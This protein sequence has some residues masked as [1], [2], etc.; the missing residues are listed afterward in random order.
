MVSELSLPR[1][2]LWQVSAPPDKEALTA[3]SPRDAVSW[4]RCVARGDKVGIPEAMIPIRAAVA[5]AAAPGDE[6]EATVA[7]AAAAAPDPQGGAQP[8]QPLP[9]GASSVQPSLAVAAALRQL[10]DLDRE[11]RVQTLSDIGATVE[12]E[13]VV[14]VPP[15]AM[16]P[17][18]PQQQELPSA[19]V[20][21]GTPAVDD[22]AVPGA[23]TTGS[24]TGG[25]K[26]VGD[27]DLCS[28]IPFF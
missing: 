5:S 17:P 22:A 23:G 20:N 25:I 2:P 12:E 8:S 10:M 4:L 27:C 1:L 15:L 28:G 16:P 13:A 21:S 24:P 3:C 11:W 26:R 9:L 6:A 7:P 14:T 19:Q 18:P